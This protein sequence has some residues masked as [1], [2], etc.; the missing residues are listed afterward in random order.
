MAGNFTLLCNEL[1]GRLK[2]IDPDS[3]VRFDST[4]ATYDLFNDEIVILLTSCPP[5]NTRIQYTFTSLDSLKFIPIPCEANQ[6]SL[7][8]IVREVAN[9]RFTQLLYHELK[10]NDAIVIEVNINNI[11]EVIFFIKA[12]PNSQLLLRMILGLSDDTTID[13]DLKTPYNLSLQ[14]KELG[15]KDT[16][17]QHSSLQQLIQI[18]NSNIQPAQWASEVMRNTANT[19]Q[20]CTDLMTKIELLRIKLDTQN[21]TTIDQLNAL[22]ILLERLLRQA[23]QDTINPEQNPPSPFP[24]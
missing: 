24:Q 4:K 5:D 14:K 22:E 11:N 9:F 10:T 20:K 15:R 3:T 1:A 7:T 23:D 2:T 18:I 19:N 6:S 21:T 16:S 12:K 17:E 13:F 8:Q